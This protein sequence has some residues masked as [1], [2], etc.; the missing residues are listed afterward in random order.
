M[1]NEEFQ[2]WIRLANTKGVGPSSFQ[3]LLYKYSSATKAIQALP[4]LY[5]NS[6]KAL[7]EVPGPEFAQQQINTARS[8]GAKIIAI[9]DAEYPTS[10]KAM[11]T[12]PPLLYTFGN[13]KLL[14]Q[15]SL[16]IVGSRNA[17]LNGTNFTKSLSQAFG[18]ANIIVISGLATGIDTAAHKGALNTGTIAVLGCGL[19]VTYPQENLALQTDIA[20]HGLLISEFPFET[21]PSAHHFPQRNRI[22]A[23]LASGT[24][25]VEAK[26]QSGSMITA[27]Y[28]LD[29]GKDVFA[30]P[31]FP[32]DPR[33]EGPN[34]LISDGATLVRDIQDILDN[35]G[36]STTLNSL[37]EFNPKDY[38][39]KPGPE[40][41]HLDAM[42]KKILS[43]LSSS[44]TSIDEIIAETNFPN[45]YVWEIILDLEIANKIQR[46]PHNK[47]SLKI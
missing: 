16:A 28:A 5:G 34:Q 3:K 27:R 24:L 31:G 32:Y 38:F 46:H 2:A 22:I 21:P 13:L 42:R 35:L 9:T 40:A 10:L 4:D 14:Y 36:T 6:R 15:Q 29:F 8:M 45:G 1:N 20:T 47:I 11:P 18:K 17:S 30:I 12:P 39:S 19:D 43:L 23:A 44:P 37:Y 41:T 33:A 7:P 26:H 25:V